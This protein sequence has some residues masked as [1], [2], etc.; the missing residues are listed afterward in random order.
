MKPIV[1]V[2]QMKK[3]LENV[4]NDTYLCVGTQGRNEIEEIQNEHKIIDA[5]FLPIGFSD[6]NE[7][8][9][10]LYIERYNES[11]CLRFQR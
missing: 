9:M 5:R 11:G 10:K 3:I 1:N 2:G 4:P 6:S 7:K 8:Y